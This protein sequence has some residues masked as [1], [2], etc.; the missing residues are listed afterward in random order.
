MDLL[1]NEVVLA[2]SIAEPK[3]IFVIA[4]V[5]AFSCCLSLGASVIAAK[6]TR[7]DID[8]VTEEVAHDQETWTELMRQLS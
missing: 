7:T 8:E 1:I 6:N 4:A 5:V 3:A 2:L